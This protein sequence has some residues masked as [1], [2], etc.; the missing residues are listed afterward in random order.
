MSQCQRCRK[1]VH[2]SC[3]PEADRALVQRKKETIGPDY[4]YLCPPCK[5]SPPPIGGE[6]TG[7]SPASFVDQQLGGDSQLDQDHHPT[8]GGTSLLAET[9]MST[10]M[11]LNGRAGQITANPMLV[12]SL[13]TASSASVGGLHKQ[14]PSVVS[15]GKIARKRMSGKGA[16]L[17]APASVMGRPKGSGKNAFAT[18]TYQSGRRAAGGTNKIASSVAGAGVGAPEF[19]RQGKRG[20]KPKMRGVFGTPGVG[21]QPRSMGGGSSSDLT[22]AGALSSSSSGVSAKMELTSSASASGEGEPCLENKLVLCSASDGFVVDQD[23]CAMCGSFGL[24]SHLLIL[25]TDFY[26]RS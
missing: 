26:N 8:S 15:A 22:G 13:S 10:K 21:L 6:D 9:L 4:D 25:F 11:S 19:A 18:A 7:S 23:T 17:G 16:G 3:D 2:S 24:V 1:Y 12:E 20:P 5:H 14:Q